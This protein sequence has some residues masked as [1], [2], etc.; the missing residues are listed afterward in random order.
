MIK[1]GYIGAGYYERVTGYLAG[2]MDPNAS[3]RYGTKAPDLALHIIVFIVT[4][5]I[6]TTRKQRIISLLV[7]APILLGIAGI[8]IVIATVPLFS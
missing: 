2:G 5:C 6:R 7:A 1:T 3:T 8:E 4:Q